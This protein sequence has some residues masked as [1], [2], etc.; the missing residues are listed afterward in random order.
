[1]FAQLSVLVLMVGAQQLPVPETLR[2]DTPNIWTDTSVVWGAIKSVSS[3]EKSGR[4]LFDVVPLGTICGLLNPT[5]TR[6]CRGQW[7][8]RDLTEGIRKILVPKNKVVFLTLRKS[9]R[10]P[11]FIIPFAEVRF[12]PQIDEC[13]PPF[14]EAHEFGSPSTR[15][16]V[17]T[18]LEMRRLVLGNSNASRYPEDK[19]D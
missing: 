4:L 12:F 14:F 6:L 3:D 1:M 19:A 15:A 5:E 17:E 10:A 2:A 13:R 7:P 9:P 8:A 16:N 18:I 11:E